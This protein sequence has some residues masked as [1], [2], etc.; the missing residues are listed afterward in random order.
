MVEKLDASILYAINEVDLSIYRFLAAGTKKGTN[1]PFLVKLR[2]D[3]LTSCWAL[4]ALQV[5]I[6]LD[7]TLT[8]KRC[9]STRKGFPLTGKETFVEKRES[10][11]TI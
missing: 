4:N 2:F 8:G 6:G 10:W 11:C 1:E 7:W 9:P 5:T 3:R